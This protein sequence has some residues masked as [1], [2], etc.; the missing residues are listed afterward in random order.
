M[1]GNVWEWTQDWYH[2]ASAR[3]GRGGSWDSVAVSLRAASRLSP[4][5]GTRFVNLGFRPAR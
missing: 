1:A 3:V 4:V 5:P 2:A